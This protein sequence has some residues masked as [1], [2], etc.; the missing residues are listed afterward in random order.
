MKINLDDGMLF[1]H[2]RTLQPK[3]F[4]QLRHYRKLDK[5][6]RISERYN[7][8]NGRKRVCVSRKA[9]HAHKISQIMADVVKDELN[10]ILRSF[11]L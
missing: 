11:H 2:N 1:T 5:K 3:S 6:N 9:E 10:D 8:R 7:P 4:F